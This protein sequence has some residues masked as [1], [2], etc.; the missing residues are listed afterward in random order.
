[1]ASYYLMDLLRNDDKVNLIDH[2]NS[3]L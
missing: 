2:V 1:M 3:T